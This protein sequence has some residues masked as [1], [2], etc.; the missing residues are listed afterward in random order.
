MTDAPAAD[1]QHTALPKLAAAGMHAVAVGVGL[2]YL[3]SGFDGVL[4]SHAPEAE[5]GRRWLLAG[6]AIVYL[7]RFLITQFVM[8]KRAFTWEEALAVGPWV[9]VLQLGLLGMGAQNSSPLG[10]AAWLGVA[11]YVL[12]SYLN[13][14]SEAQRLRWKRH[15]E[16]RGT[17]YDRGL[18]RYSQHI[19]YLG[20]SV[21][22]TGFAL[23]AGVGWTAIFPVLMTAMFILVHIPQ[24]DKRLAVHY[25]EQYLEYDA[26]TKKFIPGLW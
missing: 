26:R 3:A 14:G 6:A 24:L 4:G 7:V 9:M 21:L 2:T 10:T 8:I 11:L 16:H 12:G 5:P 13:T 22:F 19:N 17:I 23:I 18:F 20:D 1:A 15:P 25:G